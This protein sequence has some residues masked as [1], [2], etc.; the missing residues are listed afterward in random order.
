MKPP[1]SE[2]R[3]PVWLSREGDAGNWLLN[4]N[5]GGAAPGGFVRCAARRPPAELPRDQS[6]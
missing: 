2:E 1:R 6:A 4:C 5:D 3:V